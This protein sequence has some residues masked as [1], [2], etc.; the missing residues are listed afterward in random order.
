MIAFV[1]SSVAADVD[2]KEKE[3]QEV[4]C[5]AVASVALDAAD[6]N[7]TMTQRQTYAFY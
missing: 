7:N 6:P 1:G 2:E 5:N 4:D 3:V